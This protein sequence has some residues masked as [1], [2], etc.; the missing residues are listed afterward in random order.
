MVACATCRAGERNMRAAAIGL[1]AL[2]SA[3]C[4][5]NPYALTRDEVRQRVEQDRA[6]LQ[7]EQEP[8]SGSIDLYEALARALKYNLDARVK[9]M[10]IN[11]A[12]QQLDLSHYSL[13][14]QL[15]VN[16]GYD[17]RSNFAGGNAQSLL[18]GRQLL[19]P[20]TSADRDIFSANL[21]LSWDVLDFGLSYIRAQQAADNVMIAEEEKRRVAIRVI[22]EVQSA[23]WK[24]ISAERLL[25]QLGYLD[26]WVTKALINTQTIYDQKLQAPLT[27]LTYQ[28]DLLNIQREVQRLYRELSTAKIQLASL[29]NLPPGAYFEVKI[30]SQPPA[31]PVANESL[32]VMEDRALM[33]R[34]E[35]RAIDYQ[36]RINAKETKAAILEMFPNLRLSFGGYYNS[37]NFLFNNNWL[38]Y[39]AQTSW[40]L[41]NVFT[42]RAKM[43]AI[44]AQGKVLDAQSAAMAMTILTEVHV[45][46]AQLEFATQEVRNASRYRQTQRDITDQ[47]R[48]TWVTNSEGDLGLIREKVNQVLAEVRLDVAQAAVQ[49]AYA[50]LKAAV[51]EDAIP[52]I[53][54]RK[55]VAELAHALRAHWEPGVRTRQASTEHHAPPVL[56]ETK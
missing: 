54:P 31:V 9:I 43:K 23:Y 20:F 1:I 45:G 33:K 41:L 30:P 29:M 12:H 26:E 46:A 17:G 27:P 37:N 50:T 38:G 35:L 32:E 56:A 14:P 8:I 44:E 55:N 39:A 51:G 6:T 53:D 21:A 47:T 13:L 40:N 42:K 4:L 2:L 16:A 36:K 48:R 7:M 34:P 19:E 25:G 52:A 22:Q 15:A 28:R 10:Q 3:G 11:L 24:A 49:S 5:V 18:T